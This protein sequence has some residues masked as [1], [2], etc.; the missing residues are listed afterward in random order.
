LQ[1]V[2][3]SRIDS[4]VRIKFDRLKQNYDLTKLREHMKTDMRQL[5][6]KDSAAPLRPAWDAISDYQDRLV[7]P[8][9]GKQ[10]FERRDVGRAG[11]SE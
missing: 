2:E 3:T 8:K 11:R 9:Y 1:Y 6:L 4:T 10:M 7:S 5:K